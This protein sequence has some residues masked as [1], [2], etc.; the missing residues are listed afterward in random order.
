MSSDDVLAEA[1]QEIIK[2]LRA[3]MQVAEFLSRRR[4]QELAR[5]QRRS[6]EDE[7]R[8]RPFMGGEGRPAAPGWRLPLRIR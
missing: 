5:A 2:G 8:G 6:V 7:R 3:G 1:S 4:Q